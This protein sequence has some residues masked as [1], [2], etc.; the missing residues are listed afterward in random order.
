MSDRQVLHTVIFISY[1]QNIRTKRI[2][3]APNSR[4]KAA[5]DNDT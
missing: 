5:E 4:W 2:S 1:I 3:Y